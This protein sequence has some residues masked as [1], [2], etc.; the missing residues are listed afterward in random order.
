MKKMSVNWLYR[1]CTAMAIS[2]IANTGL[3]ES[4]SNSLQETL[5]LCVAA[6]QFEQAANVEL[7][8]IGWTEVKRK[9]LSD[10]A[11][12][13]FAAQQFS[14]LTFN[15]DVSDHWSK[16]WVSAK[17]YA[18]AERRYKDT[19][20]NVAVQVFE[21]RDNQSIL[22]LTRTS[23]GSK[24]QIQCDVILSAES[25]SELANVLPAPQTL[26]YPIYT[27]PRQT[28]PFGSLQIIGF[29]QNRIEAAIKEEFPFFAH[30]SV[31]SK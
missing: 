22:K 16:T 21:R 6:E 24:V 25:A 23:I 18:G 8:N 1:I 11:I 17:Q 5:N 13:G 27:F 29:D 15:S 14:L 31:V 30:F 4:G 7:S 2:A 28:T 12:L 9:E 3:A 10:H 26:P 20:P 19:N